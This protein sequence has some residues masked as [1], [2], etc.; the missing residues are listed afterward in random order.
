MPD[1]LSRRAAAARRLGA[2]IPKGPPATAALLTG[3]GALLVAAAV[4]LAQLVDIFHAVPWLG[5][6]FAADAAASALIAVAI[7]ATRLR[8]AAAAGA[9]VSAAALVGLAF[10]FTT[11]LL[12]WKETA[13][14]PAVVIAIASELVAVAALAPLA[15][16][17][18]GGARSTRSPSAGVRGRVAEPSSSAAGR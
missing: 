15:L 14:R 7:V 18:P 10:S 4:H 5:P 9:L 17:A 3:V 12:G 1:L 2:R 16:R 8:I 6:L 11:G 13:L